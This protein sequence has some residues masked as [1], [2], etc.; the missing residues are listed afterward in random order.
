MEQI[1]VTD[2]SQ[3]QLQVRSPLVSHFLQKCNAMDTVNGSMSQGLVTSGWHPWHEVETSK[4]DPL[5]LEP[6]TQKILP[7]AM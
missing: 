2:G 7:D 5:C 4:L 3:I 6:H 1:N